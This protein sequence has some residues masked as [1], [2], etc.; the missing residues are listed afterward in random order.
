MAD[1]YELKIFLET[2]LFEDPDQDVNALINLFMD[3]YYGAAGPHIL[4]YRRLVDDARKRNNG[5]VRWFPNI[6]SFQFLAD[7]DVAA[8]QA[9]FDKAEAAVR[10][11]ALLFSRVR[12]ARNGLDRL[13]TRRQGAELCYR[14]KDGTVKDIKSI[15]DSRSAAQRLQE[16]ASVGR[17]P[18]CRRKGTMDAVNAEP[19]VP[20]PRLA[21]RINAGGFRR[22]VVLRF[23]RRLL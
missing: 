21:S 3:R 19:I 2:K 13:T 6:G 8:A 11:D 10:N 20:R 12:R 4:A 14:A 22:L 7:E 23:Q 15:L 17:T 9:I 18:R 1:M 16:L 5:V